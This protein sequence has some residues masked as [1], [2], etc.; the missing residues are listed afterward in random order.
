MGVVARGV[1]FQAE[2]GTVTSL[3]EGTPL[4]LYI[5]L[6]FQ[7]VDQTLLPLLILTFIF[8]KSLNRHI[9]LINACLTWVFSGFIGCLLLYTGYQFGP[10][11]PIQLC[12]AQTSLNY[13][14]F[15]LG[16]VTIFCLFFQV[17]A[18]VTGAGWVAS[19]RNLL[20]LLANIAPIL[21]V[22]V[23][24]TITAIIA[25]NNTGLVNR[26]RRF[27]Y[28]SL[29][30]DILTDSLA[31]VTSVVLVISILLNVHVVII[32]MRNLRQFRGTGQLQHIIRISLLALYLI[33]HLI[34][35]VTS[36]WYTSSPVPDLISA[37]TGFAILV[38]FG[39]SPDVLRE[40]KR[41]ILRRKPDPPS[42]SSKLNLS[43]SST[44]SVVFTAE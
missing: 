26:S 12:I 43:E 41:I 31:I 44:S 38:F 32:V 19:R 33:M 3:I 22:V 24:T 27:F 4:Q 20:K 23:V 42:L 28:C 8:C 39:S 6:A 35:S 30:H 21:T 13:S 1:A 25:V 40:W 2:E 5:F 11:P 18:S 36:I 16:A 29:K 14:I 9:T 17:W 7:I 10:E 37:S 34:L 15:P